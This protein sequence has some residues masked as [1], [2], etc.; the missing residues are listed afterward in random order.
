MR[1]KIFCR[2]KFVKN[3]RSDQKTLK[4]FYR[5]GHL[6]IAR[7]SVRNNEFY[8]LNRHVVA[9]SCCIFI[10]HNIFVLYKIGDIH[11]RKIYKCSPCERQTRSRAMRCTGTEFEHIWAPTTTTKLGTGTTAHHEN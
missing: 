2:I 7:N 11:S 8:F 5:L 1:S 10:C 6:F 4:I 3:F 9:S